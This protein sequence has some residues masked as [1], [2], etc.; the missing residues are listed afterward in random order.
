LTKP[1]RKLVA[2][3]SP[4]NL[5][6]LEKALAE[7]DPDTTDVVVMTAKT[8]PKGVTPVDEVA[9]DPYDQQLMTAVVQKAEQAGKEVRPLIVP[10]N[11]PLHAV[12][13][14]AHDLGA[15]EVILGASNKYTADEQME[16]IA[17]VWISLHGGEPKPLTVRILSRDRDI[18]HD[19]A[20]GNRIPRISE[21]RARTVAEL[22]AAGVGVDR[23]LLV[24]DG[25]RESSDLFQAVL[26]MLD[27]Q[28][29]LAV[30]PLA[31]PAG[32]GPSLLR[33][34]QRRAE[35][36]GRD[37]HVV[38][39]RDG[40]GAEIVRLAREGQY[41]LIVLALPPEPPAS[42]LM[43]GRTEYVLRQAHCRV[44]L[45]A[46]PGIPQEVVDTTPSVG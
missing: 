30:L 28:V 42:A 7:T 37:V 41:D 1:Y 26:T 36:L 34:D 22:R 45:A 43:D 9:L 40:S 27:P 46:A 32:N 5:F 6:M 44:F 31:A 33:E 21:R 39:A 13:K 12:F 8:L 23:V 29:V 38:A 4:Q 11:D 3:R 35:Q 18:S 20:G 15:Q 10:T 25:S 19:L 17:F 14:T 2:I 16:Q 24:H